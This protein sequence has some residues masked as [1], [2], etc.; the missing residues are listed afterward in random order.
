MKRTLTLT[1]VVK[2]SDAAVIGACANGSQS[3]KRCWQFEMTGLSRMG[4]QPGIE[5]M[6]ETMDYF[7]SIHK[8]F[9][10]F[11]TGM[12]GRWL[13]QCDLQ[14]WRRISWDKLCPKDREMRELPDWI[15]VPLG[16][17]P[18]YSRKVQRGKAYTEGGGHEA[19]GYGR[20]GILW[21]EANEWM[22]K[23]SK[24]RPARRGVVRTM[25]HHHAS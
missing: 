11:K 3:I 24:K 8:A 2:D 21:R 4:K 9:K 15:R 23:H 1:W 19:H 6:M 22:Q 17:F 7:A 16:Q 14:Q 12:L 25:Q 20:Y 10:T 13:T 5:H 18:A